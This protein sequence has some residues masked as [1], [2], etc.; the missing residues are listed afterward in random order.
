[1][2]HTIDESHALKDAIEGLIR[3]GRLKE[4]VVKENADNDCEEG[5]HPRVTPAKER[6]HQIRMIFGGLYVA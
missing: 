2:G 1:M 6:G 3:K 4:Y 5:E